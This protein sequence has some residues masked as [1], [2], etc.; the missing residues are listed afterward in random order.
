MNLTK[1]M[2]C[3]SKREAIIT[4]HRYKNEHVI[5]GRP[6]GLLYGNLPGAGDEQKANLYPDRSC[7]YY[8]ANICLPPGTSLMLKGEYPHARYISFT[9]LLK[10]LFSIR[11]SLKFISANPQKI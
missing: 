4:N 1:K 11:N 6:K 8:V 9:S 10:V 3:M 7:T 5:W 2:T